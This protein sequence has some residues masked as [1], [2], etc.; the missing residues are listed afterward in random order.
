MPASP[1][2]PMSDEARLALGRM[3]EGKRFVFLGEP[4]H[5]IIEKSPYRL[6]FIQYLFEQG[7]QDVG[8]VP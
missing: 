6:T 2:E 8:R 3:L 7:W 1:E 4:D 5:F